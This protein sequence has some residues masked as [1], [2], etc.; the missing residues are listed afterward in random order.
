MGIEQP[1]F[2][3][4]SQFLLPWDLPADEC[5]WSAE[6]KNAW[7]GRRSA[8]CYVG[9]EYECSKGHRFY[10]SAGGVPVKASAGSVV[11]ENAGGVNVTADNQ[12]YTNC[13]SHT[14]LVRMYSNIDFRLN[15]QPC[16]YQ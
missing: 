6:P 7:R 5:N 3:L 9:Y 15:C 10:C 1:G 2:L 12:L 13:P 11:K 8:R 16:R 4:G 14:K